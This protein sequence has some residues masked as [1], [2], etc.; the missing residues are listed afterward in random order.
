MQNRTDEKGKMGIY[1]SFSVSKEGPFR[2]AQ[3]STYPNFGARRMR[4][5]WKDQRVLVKILVQDHHQLQK[6]K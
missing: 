1:P 6:K 4:A 3:N 2:M 5:A